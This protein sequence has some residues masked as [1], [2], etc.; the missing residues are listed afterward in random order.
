MEEQ[1]EQKEQNILTYISIRDILSR[2]SESTYFQAL[3]A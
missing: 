3:N 1:E 2:L